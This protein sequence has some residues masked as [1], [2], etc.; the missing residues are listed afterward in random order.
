VPPNQA[1]AA[2]AA[3]AAGSLDRARRFAR[4]NV[5]VLAEAV[6]RGYHIIST[7]PAAV[8]SLV[9]EYPALLD[10]NDAQLIAENISEACTFFRDLHAEGKLQQEMKPLDYTVAYHLPC[11]LKSLRVG[12]PGEELLRLIPGLSV[13]PLEAGCCGMAGTFGMRKTN[14]R[15]SIRIG[16]KLI[17]TMRDPMIDL[18]ATECSACKMQME[19]GT[20]KPAIHPIKFLAAAYGLLPESEGVFSQ[21]S[22]S[23]VVS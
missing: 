1:G 10:D 7:E 11:R 16:R 5:I 23:L 21:K 3:I 8:L 13:L 15:T 19:Q 6:R 9:R 22:G 12:S 18:G 17:A 2:T 4:R 14:Y 20:S